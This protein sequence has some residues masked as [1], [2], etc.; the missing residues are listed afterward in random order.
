MKVKNR[1]FL[2]VAVLIF[3]LYYCTVYYF[4]SNFSIS[5]MDTRLIQLFNEFVLP[6]WLMVILGLVVLVNLT[7]MVSATLFKI[8]NYN[9]MYIALAFLLTSCTS[10]LYSRCASNPMQGNW[11]E[12]CDNDPY[13]PFTSDY[14]VRFLASEVSFFPV[15]VESVNIVCNVTRWQRLPHPSIPDSCYFTED[16]ITTLVGTTDA[17]GRWTV[18]ISI[19]FASNGDYFVLEG[20]FEKP[21]YNRTLFFSDERWFYLNNVYYSCNN[22]ALGGIPKDLDVRVNLAQYNAS[23]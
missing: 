18:P 2:L 23:P 11:N 21:G 19:Q 7:K 10:G 4:N 8:R 6:S 13:F 22:P 16:I 17:N 9:F 14:S 5:F 1:S 12:E 20:S 15:P 3:A